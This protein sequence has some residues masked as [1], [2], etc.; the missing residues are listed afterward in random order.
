M[1]LSQSTYVV[2]GK[3][4]ANSDFWSQA[5]YRTW[6]NWSIFG[7]PPK[8]SALVS[9]LMK[10]RQHIGAISFGSAIAFWRRETINLVG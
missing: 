9:T 3:I 4:P 1:R 7:V 10:Q 2:L 8:T 6:K 5:R